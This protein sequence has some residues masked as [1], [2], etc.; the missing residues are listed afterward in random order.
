MNA[1]QGSRP[2]TRA[3]SSNQAAGGRTVMKDAKKWAK[4][5]ILLTILYCRVGLKI[6]CCKLA[7]M[8]LRVQKQGVIYGLSGSMC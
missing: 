7:A 1:R 2:S 3:G 8:P 5:F 4:V 6:L